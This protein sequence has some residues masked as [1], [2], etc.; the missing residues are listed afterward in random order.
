MKAEHTTEINKQVIV[1]ID[2]SQ[3]ILNFLKIYLGKE[4]EVITY[5]STSS[6]L[7]DLVSG[8]VNPDCI[9]TD[10]YL[11]NDLTGL[12]FIKKLNEIDPMIPALVLSGSCDMNQKIDCLANGAV[13]FI[14]KPFNPME[15]RVRIKNA[16]SI[17][18]S[19]NHYRHAI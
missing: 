5:T 7:N 8:N 19:L 1:A 2:D 14:Q 12:E 11:G 3:M 16:L 18:P 17:G 15:L 6:A 10:F 13:D 9:L 4:Y